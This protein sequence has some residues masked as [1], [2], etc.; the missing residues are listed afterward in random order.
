M[1]VVDC[2]LPLVSVLVVDCILLLV[3]VL[4]VDC[5]LPLVGVF[6]VDCM[7]P[8]VR[9]GPFNFQRGYGF[10]LKKYSDSQCC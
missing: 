5:I 4:V 2:I 7:L 10:F 8:L 9:D 1:L 6:V 3:S